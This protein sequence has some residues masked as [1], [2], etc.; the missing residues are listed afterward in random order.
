[1]AKRKVTRQVTAEHITN[2]IGIVRGHSV[3]LDL[4]LAALYGVE[5]RVLLQAVK[6]NMERFPAD[7]L[8]QLTAD[9][10][11]SLRSQ[12]VISKIT[13]RYILCRLLKL[14]VTN[15]DFQFANYKYRVFITVIKQQT[16]KPP[17]IREVV[18][19]I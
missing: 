16:K 8:L 13:G 14:E 5:T 12:I 17:R 18:F 15:C 7:F 1:M 4:D 9:E 19:T 10:W 3:L 11:E 6:R 2:S